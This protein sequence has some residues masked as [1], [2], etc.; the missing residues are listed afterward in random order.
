MNAPQINVLVVDDEPL[1]REKLHRWLKEEADVGRIEEAGN[2]PQALEFIDQGGIDLIFLDIQMPAMNGFEV[3]A[4]IPPP[5]LPPVVFVT[6]HERYAIEAF[7]LHALD[8]LL[9]PYDHRRFRLAFER[10]RQRHRQDH[11][12]SLAEL[13]HSMEQT[14][15]PQ[16]RRFAVRQGDGILLVDANQVDWLEAQGN[17]VILHLGDTRHMIRDSLGQIERRPDLDGFI[18]IHRSTM[19]NIDRIQRL[20]PVSHGDCLVIL[21]DGRQ[22]LMSRTYR[23]QTRDALKLDF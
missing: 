1:A 8:Y 10:A 23:Q 2:G 20:Q 9:K 6:A 7:E 13:L 14:P 21:H 5:S 15:K 11:S 19:V 16:A 4:Q 3:L 12:A 18:R 17:Y 22:L